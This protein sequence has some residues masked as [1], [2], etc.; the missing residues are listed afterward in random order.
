VT[1]PLF[2]VQ[3]KGRMCARL[4]YNRGIFQRSIVIRALLRWALSILGS[5][6]WSAPVP[7]CGPLRFR[8]VVRS[9]SALWSARV[10]A[11]FARFESHPAGPRRTRISLPFWACEGYLG[12]CSVNRF[13]IAVRRRGGGARCYLVSDCCWP[14]SPTAVPRRAQLSP[15]WKLHGV[16]G[17]CSR[18]ASRADA[19]IGRRSARAGSDACLPDEVDRGRA[20]GM[21]RFRSVFFAMSSCLRA[22]PSPSQKRACRAPSLRART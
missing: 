4:A 20:P 5:A 12:R 11:P 15:E 14:S 3:I 9:G 8:S 2:A 18:L 1:S 10:H 7:L 13:G 16:A 6:L 19:A 17:D 22:G 21:A